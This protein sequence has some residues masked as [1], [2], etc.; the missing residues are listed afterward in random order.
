MVLNLCLFQLPQIGIGK[1]D[2]ENCSSGRYSRSYADVEI[3]CTGIGLYIRTL[4]I[5]FSVNERKIETRY[6]LLCFVVISIQRKKTCLT[7]LKSSE[8]FSLIMCLDP[9]VCN[10]LVPS[11]V[12]MGN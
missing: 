11:R 9:V 7:Q 2:G 10:N 1:N 3:E 4:C 6:F 8:T 5:V 12:K